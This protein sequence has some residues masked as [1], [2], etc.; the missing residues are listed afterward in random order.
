MSNTKTFLTIALI[1]SNF[2]IISF[3]SGTKKKAKVLE[4]NEK[5]W[6]NMFDEN[7]GVRYIIKLHDE[8]ADEKKLLGEVEFSY[9]TRTKTGKID[10][11]KIEKGVR[12]N[13]FGERLFLAGITH[14]FDSHE[15]NI[16]K[17]N[18]T[19]LPFENDYRWNPD[20]LEK[21]IKYY[22]KRGATLVKRNEVENEAEMEFP[23]ERAQAISLHKKLK[24]IDKKFK[25]GCTML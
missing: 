4:T 25:F 13:G 16:Q 2:C 14:L 20:A 5:P 8:V 23:L 17:I 19:A 1:L 10:S 18:L 12:K 15:A 22:S 9:C 24:K 21:L 6:F 3:A 7:K 11:L